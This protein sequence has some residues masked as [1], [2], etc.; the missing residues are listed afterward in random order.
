VV[1][2]DELDH[3]LHTKLTR[4]LIQSYLDAWHEKARSQLFFTTHDV[5]LFDL[6]LF[7]R[8]EMALVEKNAEGE[9]ELK[10]VSDYAVRSDKRLMKDYWLGRYGAVPYT[11][12]LQLRRKADSAGHKPSS[13]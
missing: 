6:D 7:R 4:T 8:D 12:T 1:F 13:K 5:T 3:S 11:R 2:V 9:T 10:A